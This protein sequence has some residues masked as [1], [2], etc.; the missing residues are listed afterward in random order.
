M[1]TFAVVLLMAAGVLALAWYELYGG[2][3]AQ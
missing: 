1:T 2:S 3:N